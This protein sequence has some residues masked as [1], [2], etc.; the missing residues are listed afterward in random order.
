M[1]KSE[2]DEN[3]V[4]I[5]LIFIAVLINAIIIRVASLLLADSV[6]SLGTFLRIAFLESAYTALISPLLFK[7]A[8]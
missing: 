2:Q 6:A 8:K 1:I 4:Y 5:A 3:F 7:L